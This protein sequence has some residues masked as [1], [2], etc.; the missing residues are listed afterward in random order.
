MASYVPEKPKDDVVNHPSHYTQGGIECIDALEAA[1]QGKPPEEAILA[2]NAIKY[3][4]RYN[5]KEPVRSLKSARWY[6]DRLIAKVEKRC[7]K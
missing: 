4:W 7:G 2:A 3:L 5:L 1:V 6:I